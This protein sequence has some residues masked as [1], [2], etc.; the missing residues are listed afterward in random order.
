MDWIIFFGLSYYIK[1]K[2]FFESKISQAGG[3]TLTANMSV[4]FST[5]DFKVDSYWDIMYKIEQ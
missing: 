1:N 2:G 5:F 4:D 3:G